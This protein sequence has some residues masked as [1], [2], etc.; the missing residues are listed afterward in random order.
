LIKSLQLCFAWL[1]QNFINISV[2]AGDAQAKSLPLFGPHGAKHDW[3]FILGKY[4]ILEWDYE[5]AMAFMVLAV[6]SFLVGILI[7]RFLK[8]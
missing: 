4:N 1:G 6:L 7:P 5:I 2:Y 3:N 8:D